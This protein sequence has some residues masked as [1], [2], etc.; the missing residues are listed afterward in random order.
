[1]TEIDISHKERGHSKLGASGAERWMEC[2]GSVALL[3]ELKLPETDEPSWTREGTALHEA[4]EHCLRTG[5]DTWEI[6]GQTF[7]ETV[8][9]QPMCDAIQIYV[10][11]CRKDMDTAAY[12]FIETALSSPQT[13]P[14]MF[15][16]LD[17]AA[18]FGTA[19]KHGEFVIPDLVVVTDL[20]GGEGIV[21]E[22]D[23]NPQLKYYAFMLIDKNPHWV[24]E[25]RV[26]LRIVQPRAFHMDG[27]VREWET[28]VGEIREWVHDTLVPAMA[29]TEYDNTLDPGPWCRFCAAKLVC[30]MLT[31]LFRAAAVANPKEV[32]NYSDAS[33]ARSY[34]YTQAVKF[35]LKA[36]EEET[37][38]RLN[39]GVEMTGAVKLVN[40]KANRVF[41][42]GAEAIFR[43]KLGGEAL[44]TTHLK[45]PAEL[46]KVSPAAKELVK[47][48]AYM[49]T[50][51]TTV[52]MWDDPRRE[53]KVKSSTEA[54][55]AALA[56][57]E[58]TE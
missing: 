44:T 2:P 6:L 12:Y 5:V 33:I 55:G 13:H 28:T 37:Y 31:S 53:V 38:R 27:G 10:D 47:E 42:D 56:Q 54:F 50:T 18:I 45:S 49:P 8:L 34:Q 11:T 32:V 14:D 57:L 29:R 39:A 35:Y 24:D 26:L 23:D 48:W 43:E 46:E 17:F 7:N 25:T 51:G 58:N 19:P 4:S 30:P 20:K 21:V 9:D 36:L 15:G 3:A 1:M 52:A 16:M 41:K 40:K 22:P